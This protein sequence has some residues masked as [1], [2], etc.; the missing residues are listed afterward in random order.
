[1]LSTEDDFLR[2]LLENPDDV[3][4]LRYADWLDERADPLGP[5]ARA[6]A[7]IFQYIAD[8]QQGRYDQNHPLIPLLTTTLEGYAKGGNTNLLRGLALALRKYRQVEGFT[9]AAPGVASIVI[10]R[11]DCLLA[12]SPGADNVEA[13]LAEV[14][15]NADFLSQSPRHAALLA[16]AQP[17]DV[18]FGI[19]DRHRSDN[20]L[21]ELMSCLVQE[22][23]IRGV[24]FP[25]VSFV[26][27]LRPESHPLS[28]LPLSLTAVE[29]EASRWL[30][31]YYLG[32]GWR[33][34]GGPADRGVPLP[35]G[36]AP[37]SPE[38]PATVEMAHDPRIRA[39]LGTFEDVEL[40]VF[41]AVAPVREET[42]SVRF[43]Q[44]LGLPCLEGA[45][46]ETIRA[47]RGRPQDA[48]NLLF[49]IASLGGPVRSLRG[50]YE[51]LAAW[52]SLAGL[53]GSP[54]GSDVEAVS[55]LAELSRWV[56]FDAS[57]GWFQRG[58]WSFGILAVRPD[59]TTLAVLAATNIA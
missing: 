3:T 30:P 40:H 4:R 57:S 41:R 2:A 35:A 46:F 32:G 56:L 12:Q 51:R 53:V 23:V 18:L 22:M 7:E 47:G 52:V 19:L 11:I 15:D 49:C 17:P 50:A 6:H 39:A 45:P 20:H 37:D 8:L 5:S 14:R 31:H 13:F 16:S 9:P 43:L 25:D 27:S 29:S 54:V 55:S 28:R 38:R 59:E 26:D 24:R 58:G 10:D 44:K 48:F 1:V 33:G 42:M 34:V 21:F 36:D